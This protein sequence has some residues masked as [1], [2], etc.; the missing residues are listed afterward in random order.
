MTSE[1]GQ[2]GPRGA[3]ELRWEVKELVCSGTQGPGTGGGGV[4][5]R[6]PGSL[7]C[8]RCDISQEV[9]SAD[10]VS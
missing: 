7:K 8:P 3:A 9:A 2:E 5:D 4:I 6:A 10:R 1:R